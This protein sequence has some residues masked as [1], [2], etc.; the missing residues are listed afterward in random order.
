MSDYQR[1]CHIVKNK[2]YSREN[3]KFLYDFVMELFPCELILEELH[4]TVA[5]NLKNQ[6]VI[7][8]M[9]FIDVLKSI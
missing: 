9:N 3:K 1:A 7:R 4:K 5:V 8:D 6:L 2:D